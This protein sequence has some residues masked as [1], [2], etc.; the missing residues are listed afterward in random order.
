MSILDDADEPSTT[1]GFGEAFDNV[2]EADA[3]G[4]NEGM[5]GDPDVTMRDEEAPW[6]K[7]FRSARR[8]FSHLPDPRIVAHAV[9]QAHAAYRDASAGSHAYPPSINVVLDV[10]DAARVLA[11]RSLRAAAAHLQD[12]ATRLADRIT[13]T[14]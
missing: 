8:S 9:A 5:F 10:A 7:A 11:Y 2:V 1:A 13:P 6:A 3:P 12:F 4:D 14:H